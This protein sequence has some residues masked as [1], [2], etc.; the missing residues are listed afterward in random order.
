MHGSTQ[1][2]NIVRGRKSFDVGSRGGTLGNQRSEYTLASVLYRYYS[3]FPI[4][5]FTI[6]SLNSYTAQW[7]TNATRCCSTFSS[8]FILS[9]RNSLSRSERYQAQSSTTLTPLSSHQLRF[10]TH[11]A[12]DLSRTCLNGPA[13]RYP[14]TE[15]TFRLRHPL[16]WRNTRNCRIQFDGSCNPPA[17]APTQPKSLFVTLLTSRSPLRKD[18][19]EGDMDLSLKDSYYPLIAGR[20][21][22]ASQR[23]LYTCSKN[24]EEQKSREM[25]MTDEAQTT[26]YT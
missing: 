11:E 18:G 16:Q 23:T 5:S 21:G 15:R 14:S 26:A 25:N 17:L 13:S 7:E 10:I 2:K 6:E 20:G 9:T 24:W 4:G 22:L 1:R 19:C 12:P 8:K 3:R